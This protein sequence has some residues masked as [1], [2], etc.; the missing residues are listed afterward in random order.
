VACFLVDGRWLRDHLDV[1]FTNG[2][3]HHSRRYV[4]RDEVWIDR[5]APGAGEIP[6]HLTHQL[7]ERA[8]MAAGASYLEALDRATRRE[9]R[10]RRATLARHLPP[11]EAREALRLERLEAAGGDAVWLVD[12]RG[13]RDRFCPEFTL[14]GHGL[15]YRFIPRREIWIDDAVV[16]RERH[17]IIA[18]EVL[19]LGLM[20]RGLSYHAAHRR[21]SALERRLRRGG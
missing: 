7:T 12:G 5:E 19:E 10:A 11:R 21:A 14:G 20:R 8:L 13:V 18:H 6:F 17:L 9:R 4:P 3:H 16:Q 2:A 15:R 1:E